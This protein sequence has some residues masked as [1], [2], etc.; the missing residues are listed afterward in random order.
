MKRHSPVPVLDFKALPHPT[1]IVIAAWLLLLLV[2]WDYF[3]DD[4]GQSA[5]NSCCST[6]IIGI[7]D[8]I[9]H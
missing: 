7:Y 1:G 3:R 6:L 4:P 5:M 9:R 2:E 8:F